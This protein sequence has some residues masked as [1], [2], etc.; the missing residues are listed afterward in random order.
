MESLHHLLTDLS[1]ASQR[2]VTGRLN[3]IF[4]SLSSPRGLNIFIVC[5]KRPLR[6][7]F[8]SCKCDRPEKNTKG[9]KKTLHE[10]NMDMR[11]QKVNLQLVKCTCE[12]LFHQKTQMEISRTMKHRK[13]GKQFD[14]VV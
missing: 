3:Q 6:F 12:I 7:S 5:N 13:Y 11:W 1:D 4:S 10:C 8:R 14:R 2:P 9:T